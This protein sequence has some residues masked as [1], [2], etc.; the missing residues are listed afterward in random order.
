MPAGGSSGGSGGGQSTFRPIVNLS[1]RPRLGFVYRP[2]WLLIPPGIQPGILAPTNIVR[3]GHRGRWRAAVASPA[4]ATYRPFTAHSVQRPI[5][6]PRCLGGG[7]AT[8]SHALPFAAALSPGHSLRCLRVSSPRR[9][10]SGHVSLGR[11]PVPVTAVVP[12]QPG[13]FAPTNIVRVGKR[14]KWRAAAA[15][16]LGLPIVGCPFR[17][18][19]TPVSSP[20]RLTPGHVLLGRLPVPAAYVVPVSFGMLAPT[21]IVRADNKQRWRPA[22]AGPSRI[23]PPVQFGMLAPTTIIRSDNKQR[24]WPA[25]AGPSGAI[26][27]YRS[28]TQKPL[29]AFRQVNRSGRVWMQ[30]GVPQSPPKPL[31]STRAISRPSPPVPGRVWL[32]KLIHAAAAPLAAIRGIRTSSPRRPTPGHVSLG[33]FPAHSAVTPPSQFGATLRI[34]G[35][36]QRPHGGRVWLPR[37][38]TTGYIGVPGPFTLPAIPIARRRGDDRARWHAGWQLHW[39]P[40]PLFGP[41]IPVLGYHIYSNAGSGPINYSTAIATVYGV[42]WT[43]TALAHPDTWMFGVRAFD[44]YGEEQ[45]LDATVTLILNAAGQDITNQP[46]PPVAVRALATAGGGI[47]VEWSYNVVNPMPIPTGFHVYVGTVQTAIL[48]PVNPISRSGR[49]GKVG[50]S[51]SIHW[52]GALG[53]GMNYAVPAATVSF[54]S[55]IAGTFVANIP[56]LVNGVQYLVGVRAYNGVAEE[57][58]VNVVSVKANSVGPTA[59][60]SLTATAIA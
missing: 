46:K 9:P 42:T 38:S 22:V 53:G 24:W 40:S 32:P 23:T 37:A 12:I 41:A 18:A 3:V 49:H 60:V 56:G 28:L 26:G 20:R 15:G 48:W 33:R 7:Q 29:S 27:F 36:P 47:R 13:T 14:A 10:I 11:F 39:S 51:G 19:Q 54:Q 59:V 2:R 1:V 50:R 8:F 35:A 30:H 44:G 43:S 52:R 45:N 58:N 34:I 31:R 55:A 21:N 5:A 17:S 6:S 57:N 25:V 4:A 16:S